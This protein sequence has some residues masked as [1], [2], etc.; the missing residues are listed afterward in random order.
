[1]PCRNPVGAVVC[2]AKDWRITAPTSSG[3]LGFDSQWDPGFYWPMKQIIVSPDDSSRDMGTVAS[4]ITHEGGQR[5]TNRVLFTENHDQ[6]APQNGQD[7]QRLPELIWPGHADSYYAQKRSTLGAAVMLTSPGIP[8]LFMGQEFLENTPFPFGADVALDWTK[9][10]SHAGILALY[11][12]LIALRRNTGGTTRGLTGEH[13]N[14]FH[15]D[16]TDKLI[17]WHRSDA[18]GPGDDV[19]VVANFSSQPRVGVRIGVPTDGT[20]RVRLNS[21]R[22][23]YSAD[24]H[25]TKTPDLVAS[26]TPADGF[27]HSG[28]VDIGPYALVV[29]SVDR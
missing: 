16:N 28:L 1:M 11:H 13:V 25:D 23:V 14:V 7:D 26:P 27:S 12:D 22:A 24:F 18:G 9:T 17:A 2:G 21:D 4:A 10:T 5:A 29:Y 8:M 3:G 20:Y 6:V 19:V 15:V